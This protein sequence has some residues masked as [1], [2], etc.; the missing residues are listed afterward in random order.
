[1][2]LHAYTDGASR[3]NPGESGIGMIVQTPEGGLLLSESGYIGRT[4]NNIAEYTAVLTLL[5]RVRPMDCSRLIIHS[6][7]E[8]MVRQMTG[9]YKVKNGGLK[10]CHTRARAAIAAL[11]FPVEFRHVPREENRGADRLANEGIDSRTPLPAGPQV[12]FTDQ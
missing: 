4:T 9:A 2:I 1:M 12:S 5:D 8:L 3:G 7:S 6:D 11:P 10:E